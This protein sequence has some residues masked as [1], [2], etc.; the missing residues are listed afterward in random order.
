[1]KN[2]RGRDLSCEDFVCPGVSG[3]MAGLEAC[4]QCM[5]PMNGLFE[6]PFHQ[7]S[8]AITNK[9]AL[10]RNKKPAPNLMQ[11]L[12]YCSGCRSSDPAGFLIACI[13]S[14]NGYIAQ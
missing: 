1:M 9:E 3:G 5:G 7:W 14:R 4:D 8:L 12:R 13:E 6:F 10:S 11:H 2:P